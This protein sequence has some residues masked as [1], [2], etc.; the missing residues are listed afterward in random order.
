[1]I[2]SG[3]GLALAGALGT[4]GASSPTRVVTTVL[5]A[6]ELNDT[7]VSPGWLGF[8]VFLAMAFITFLLLR[9]FLKQLR[10]VRV[11]EEARS[12][13]DSDSDAAAASG[14]GGG[15]RAEPGRPADD[16]PGTR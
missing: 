1:M 13:S 4:T 2:A 12:D 11:A 5:S 8:G 14:R 10:K 7:T 16:T 9:S 3:V 6:K 15:P